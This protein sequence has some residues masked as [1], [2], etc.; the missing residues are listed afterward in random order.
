[1][2]WPEPTLSAARPLRDHGFH[3]LRIDRV[4]RE[5]TAAVSLVLE[6]PS[7]LSDTFA[8]RSGQFCNV[9]VQI[10]GIS[11][12]RCYSMSSSP[13]LGEEMAVTVK[14]VPGGIVSNWINDHVR[15]GD[16]VELAPPTGFFQLTDTSAD[17]VAFAAGSG[18]TP[19][20]S[21]LK[22]ALATTARTIRLHYANRDQAGVIFDAELRELQRLHPERLDVVHSYDVEHGLLTPE[23]VTALATATAVGEFYICGPGPYMDIVERG[24]ST[25]DVEKGRIHIERFTQ[26]DLPGGAAAL[27]PEAVG[28][29]QVTVD[30]DGR[31]DT[32][33]HRQGTTILQTARQM[34]MSPPFSCESG[35]CATCMA[36]LVR[37]SVSMFVNNALTA[38]EVADGWILTCQS[39]PTAPAVHVVYDIEDG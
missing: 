39:V 29:T 26:A 18:I 7:E 1:M 13:A 17:L 19:V 25:L 32:T 37:G 31:S 10:D 2:A 8:Y 34:G 22:T 20:F 9:R 36:R 35:N 16:M 4:V 23:T 33:D 30:L 28:G 27:A 38:E 11:E 3:P 6:V 12:M 24:L 21:L 14:R 5:T 15:A